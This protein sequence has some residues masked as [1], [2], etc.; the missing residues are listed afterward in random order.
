MKI[1]VT[2]KTAYKKA[3]MIEENKIRKVLL[4]KETSFQDS[5]IRHWGNDV[6]IEGA[7]RNEGRTRDFMLLTML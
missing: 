7:S 1:C 3:E 4:R 2:Y 6:D 5:E